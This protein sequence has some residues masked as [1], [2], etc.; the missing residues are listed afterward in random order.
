[1]A[2][3]K[4][5]TEA[6]WQTNKWI[7]LLACTTSGHIMST[8]ISTSMREIS[9]QSA[10]TLTVQTQQRLVFHGLQTHDNVTLSRIKWLAVSEKNRHA[11]ITPLTSHK[12]LTGDEIANL[13]FYAV[14]P[15]ANEFAEITPLHRSRSFKV[16][17]LGTNR[18]LIYDLKVLNAVEILPK[19]WTAWIGRTDVTDDRQTDGR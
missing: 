6:N 1:M 2:V 13:N 11:A 8:K 7:G 19:I 9:A 3:T 17:D 5:T 15:E 18:K 16:T 14:H 4:L 12:N 10:D